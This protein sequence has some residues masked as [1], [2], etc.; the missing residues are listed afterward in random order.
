MRVPHPCA[1]CAQG[2]DSAAH[3]RARANLGEALRVIL[4]EQGPGH[5]R[6][7]SEMHDK[8]PTSVDEYKKWLLK[9]RGCELGRAGSYYDSVTIKAKSDLEKSDLWSGLR[10]ELNEFND[11]YQ[12]LT[13]F[14]LLLSGQSLEIYVKPFESFVL[15]TFRKTCSAPFKTGHEGPCLR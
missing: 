11:Q 15:K 10:S 9:E 2:W 8:K 12:G 13:G 1:F 14:P 6:P 5:Q 7:V 4:C 3:V